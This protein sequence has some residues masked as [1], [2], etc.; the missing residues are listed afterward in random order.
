MEFHSAALDRLLSLLSASFKHRTELPS[1][2]SSSPCSNW[3]TTL[4]ESVRSRQ[5]AQDRLVSLRTAIYSSILDSAAV[6]NARIAGSNS[7]VGGKVSSEVHDSAVALSAA[8]NLALRQSRQAGQS[9]RI[10]LKM[11]FGGLPA[12]TVKK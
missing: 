6:S 12:G 10:Q 7:A 4:E 11:D 2:L 3:K 8:K 9:R 5:Q 1:L